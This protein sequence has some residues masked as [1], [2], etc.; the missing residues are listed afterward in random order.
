MRPEQLA[1][2]GQG[3]L[4]GALGRLTGAPRDRLTAQIESIDLA[5]LAQLVDEL[6]RGDRAEDHGALEP[7]DVVPLGGDDT[8]A[9]RAG[10]ALLRDDAVAAVLVAGGQ[11]TRLG[12]DGPKGAF[13]F[14]P[15]TERTLFSQHAARIAAMRRRYGASLPWYIMTSPQNDDDTRAFFDAHDWFGLPRDSVRLFV[16]GQ[17]PAVDRRT[18]RILL[19][20]PDRVALSPDGHGGLF[21]ALE[22]SGVLGDMRERGIAT[23]VTFN[24]DNPLLRV[25]DPRFLGHHVLAG[26]DMSNVVVRKT[27]PGERVGVVAKRDG[28]TVLVEY[29]DLSDELAAQRDGDELRF[30]AGSV[31]AHAI[32][33]EFAER[34]GREGGLPFHRAAK[35]VPYVDDDGRAVEPDGPNAVKFESFMFDALPMARDALS[36]EVRRDEEFSPIKNAE[37]A[38]SPAT[39]RRDLNRLN[40]RWLREAGVDVEVDPDGVPAVDIDI[41]PRYA[42][43]AEELRERLPTDFTPT[44]GRPIVLGEDAWPVRREAVGAPHPSTTSGTTSGSVGTP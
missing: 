28:R 22:R 31:A 41:D 34:I 23:F 42:L 35:A 2:L 20:A 29:S 4:A 11:G 44:P 33:R 25:A 18:G 10:E 12:Y 6:V 21:P 32:Q 15:A 9:I 1:D 36:V 16:Q 13:P 7:P 24:V 37:G 39:A 27:D 5:R 19:E 30:W 38:D 43:D 14:A 8:D 40:A 3:H 17:M 26:A